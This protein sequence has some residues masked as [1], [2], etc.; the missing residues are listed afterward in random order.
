MVRN[1]NWKVRGKEVAYFDAASTAALTNSG[2]L[3]KSQGNWGATQHTHRINHKCT[4]GELPLDLTYRGRVSS[5]PAEIKSTYEKKILSFC[6][7]CLIR[8]P[9]KMRNVRSVGCYYILYRSKYNV[10][11]AHS[12]NLRSSKGVQMLEGRNPQ[13]GDFTTQQPSS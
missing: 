13:H 11:E 10:R 4:S 12:A 5:V 3:W 7:E 8:K 9:H 1:S 2:T 6:W